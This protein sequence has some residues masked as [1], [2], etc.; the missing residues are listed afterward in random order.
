MG[1]KR[2]EFSKLLPAS[3][4]RSPS[5]REAMGSLN[6]HTTPWQSSGIQLV[7]NTCPPGRKEFVLHMLC[8]VLI[9]QKEKKGSSVLGVHGNTF[10]AFRELRAAV[11]SSDK[12]G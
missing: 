9:L 12:K 5:H 6:S 11:C 3:P 4:A 10:E 1:K 8:H 2:T 7:L